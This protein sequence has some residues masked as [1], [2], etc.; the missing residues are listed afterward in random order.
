MSTF[1]DPTGKFDV[2]QTATL[3][4]FIVRQVEARGIDAVTVLIIA[5]SLYFKVKDLRTNGPVTWEQRKQLICAAIDW[6][7]KKFMDPIDYEAI[8]PTL[9]VIL[10]DA[11]E[12]LRDIKRIG[13][14]SGICDCLFGSKRQAK[15]EVKENLDKRLNNLPEKK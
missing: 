8:Q 14:G 11:L 5:Q 9:K 1:Q 13:K 10:P 2:Q 7:A 4:G 6:T 3:V 12:S 15:Q